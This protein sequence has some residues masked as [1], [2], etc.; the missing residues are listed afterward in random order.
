MSSRRDA[1]D[2]WISVTT[3]VSAGRAT[4]RV[5]NSGPLIAP[6]D[7]SRLLEPFHARPRPEIQ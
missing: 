5:R 1:P 7:V 3:G 2:G 4:L 6:G